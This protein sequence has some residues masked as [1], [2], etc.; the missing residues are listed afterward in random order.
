[1]VQ[2][3]KGLQRSY[4][5]A[6]ESAD[7]EALPR[8]ISPQAGQALEILGHAIDY[9]TDEYL[10]FISRSPEGVV[11]PDLA[12]DYEAVEILKALNRMIYL[13][14]PAAPTWRQRLHA[15]LGWH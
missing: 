6:Q 8:R 10:V 9:L 12:G 2:V 5:A 14:C 15:L 7:A 1:M 3:R 4:I 11:S 13:Q